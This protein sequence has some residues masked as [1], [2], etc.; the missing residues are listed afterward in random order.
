MEEIVGISSFNTNSGEIGVKK[1][2]LLHLFLIYILCCFIR[3]P[4]D[5]LQSHTAGCEYAASCIQPPSQHPGHSKPDTVPGVPRPD[6]F[7]PSRPLDIPHGNDISV[8]AG[9]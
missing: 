1:E 5:F 8:P 9:Y 2:M 7:V 6:W 4:S 3:F